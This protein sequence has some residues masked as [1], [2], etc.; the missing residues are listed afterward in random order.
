MDEGVAAGRHAAQ[1][2]GRG[3]GDL[4]QARGEHVRLQA[5]PAFVLRR[6]AGG[7]GGEAGHPVVLLAQRSQP[8]HG[9]GGAGGEPVEFGA[10]AG[11][12]VACGGGLTDGAVGFLGGA[13]GGGEVGGGLAGGCRG[14]RFGEDGAYGGLL[15]VPGVQPALQLPV[16]G[17][18]EEGVGGG[19][20]GVEARAEGGV[21]EAGV[22]VLEPPGRGLGGAG[23]VGGVGEQRGL[24]FELPGAGG[25]AGRVSARLRQLLLQGDAFEVEALPVADAGGGADGRVALGGGTQLV[26]AFGGAQLLLGCVQ[27]GRGLP[28]AGVLPLRLVEFAGEL[29]GRGVPAPAPAAASSSRTAASRW[30]ASARRSSAC[31]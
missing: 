19:P 18:V 27:R 8:A 1:P 6:G 31:W 24:P 10:A 3:G 28:R 23:G 20:R 7:E 14:L 26:F 4:L 2:D 17:V 29:L 11:G 22:G 13:L 12:G 30:S 16:G 15:V 21:G 9:V 5:H 25:D